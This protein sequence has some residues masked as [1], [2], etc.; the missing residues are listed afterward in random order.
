MSSLALMRLLESA[1]LRY[2]A[3]M[4]LLTLGKID[5]IRAALAELAVAAPGA[6]VLEIGCGTGAVTEK[7]VAR[8]ACVTAYDQNPEMLEQAR[9][10]LKDSPR[11]AV[12]LVERT[13]A[14][15]DSCT[16]R[17]FDAV[18]ACLSLSEM[19]R[20]ER[21]FV[22]AQ[23]FR[24]L[25]PGGILAIADEARPRAAALRLWL[26]LLRVPQ[27][28]F[29]WLIVGSV[30]RPIPNLVKEV[31]AAGFHVRYERRWLLQSLALV[32]AERPL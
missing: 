6:R 28:A 31:N 8:G 32:T 18:V 1:P 29:A 16:E 12:K 25:R 7:L 14:E 13:A 17:S 27:A 9:S 2:D 15:I 30:S 10:R 26:W 24:A 11:D 3:G 19:S 23:A 5:E 4:R 21:D 20:S 22:L